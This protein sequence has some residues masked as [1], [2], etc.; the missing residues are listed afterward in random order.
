MIPESIALLG[1]K[2]KDR[3]TGFAGVV[4]SVTFDLYGCVQAL[5]TPLCK[6]D[7]P[8]ADSYWFD[9]KRLMPNGDRVM[10]GPTFGAMP[11]D[12]PGGNALPQPARTPV[13]RG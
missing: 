10:D 8:S 12:I 13:P 5:L 7:G 2:M 11:A 6:P 9:V 1:L 3:V 4:T